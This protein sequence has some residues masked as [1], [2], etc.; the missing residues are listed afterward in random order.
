MTCISHDRRRD[1]ERKE[2]SVTPEQIKAAELYRNVY[3]CAHGA[4]T[5]ASLFADFML[6]VL[7][8]RLWESGWYV[9]S[10]G[11]EKLTALSLSAFIEGGAPEGLQ[12]SLPWVAATL[13]TAAQLGKEAADEAYRLFNDQM[14]VEH[15]KTAEELLDV[16]VMKATPKAAEH[17]TNQY[18]GGGDNVTSIKERGNTAAYTL[19][20]L[21]RDRPDLAE[22]V[23]AGELSANA[24]AIEAGFRKKQTP[25]EALRRSWSRATADERETFLQEVI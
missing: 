18:T 4:I 8:N 15:G 12:S 13:K 19:A 6:S 1:G 22:R 16:A 10:R 11:N 3:E 17:G 20:R 25:L 2:R 21:K 14:R 24:A 9:P 23:V 5:D 7:R